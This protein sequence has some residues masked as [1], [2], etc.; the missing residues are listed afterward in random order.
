MTQESRVI[1]RHRGTQ[2]AATLR[3]LASPGSAAPTTDSRAALTK[4]QALQHRLTVET[5]DETTWTL[6]VEAERL[7]AR[8]VDLEIVFKALRR[9]AKAESVFIRCAAYRWLASLH[10]KDLRFEMR[11]KRLLL[12]ALH[13]ETDVALKRVTDLLRR[14]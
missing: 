11:A 1:R 9:L 13:E 7:P 4:G 3:L 5:D 14:C 8:S 6:L 12:Q 2:P 10:Q